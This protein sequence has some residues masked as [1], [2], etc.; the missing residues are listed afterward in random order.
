MNQ[1]QRH[2]HVP[3]LDIDVFKGHGVP[4]DPKTIPLVI[5]SLGLEHHRLNDAF[6]TYQV[7]RFEKILHWGLLILIVFLYI[8]IY[9]VTEWTSRAFV[10][11][12]E[13]THFCS[14]IQSLYRWGLTGTDK[15]VVCTST[16]TL[17]NQNAVMLKLI[18]DYRNRYG[19][20][21]YQATSFTKSVLL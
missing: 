4:C 10:V 3:Q 21:T 19:G 17:R 15:P 13:P 14:A 9:Y 12:D 8:Y 20:C 11:R 2:M 5:N 6:I 1:K 16:L 18:F 7:N